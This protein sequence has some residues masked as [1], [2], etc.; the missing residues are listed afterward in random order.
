M[1]THCLHLSGTI[2]CDST[3]D[4]VAV[5][6]ALNKVVGLTVT[7]GDDKA[8]KAVSDRKKDA[9]PG[10]KDKQSF[11]WC[12]ADAI[13]EL[14][15]KSFTRQTARAEWRKRKDR[16]NSLKAFIFLEKDK[17]AQKKYKADLNKL[18]TSI[19]QVEERAKEIFVR[20]YGEAYTE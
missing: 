5:V 1:S 19:R 11:A 16:A 6:T 4:L 2:T 18:Q 10:R 9:N 13:V 7:I 20:R 12:C 14:E 17:Q 3:S 8:G 15:P